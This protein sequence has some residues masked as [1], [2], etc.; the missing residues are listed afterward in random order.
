[1]TS[2]AR[3]LLVPFAAAVA[4]FIAS[5]TTV[6]AAGGSRPT[7]GRSGGSDVAEHYERGIAAVKAEDYRKALKHFEKARKA[8]RKNPDVLNMLGYTQRK[9]GKL[10]DAFKSYEEAL[11]RRKRFPQA[12]EYLAEAHLQAALMQLQILESYGAD[13]V[14]E[15]KLLAQAL[16]RAAD[17]V[18]PNGNLKTGAVAS[19]DW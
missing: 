14:N 9:L 1:M 18:D 19:G 2:K 15:R 5:E 4:L 12:R 11:K 6:D 8:D 7:G 3:K 13:A 10:K 16:R 17:A